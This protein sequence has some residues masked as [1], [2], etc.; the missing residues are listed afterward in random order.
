[1][2]IRQ[3]HI[4]ARKWTVS[5]LNLCRVTVCTNEILRSSPRPSNKGLDC[6]ISVKRKKIFRNSFKFTI[7]QS[8]QIWHCAV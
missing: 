8:V 6:N 3:A 5:G 7:H 1:M 4:Q 2:N